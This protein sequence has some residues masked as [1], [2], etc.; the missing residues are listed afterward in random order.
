MPE[1]RES[2]RSA[3]LGELFATYP[4]RRAD[5]ASATGLSNATVSRSVEGLIAEGLA[6]EID[7]PVQGSRGRPATALEIVPDRAYVA[8]V[9][10]GAS[11]TRI[12]VADAVCTV[13]SARSVPTPTD[14]GADDLVSWLAGELASDAARLSVSLSRVSV[15]LPG[16]VHLQ[17]HSVTNAPNLAVVERPGFFDA[18][19]RIADTQLGIDNDANYALMG[20]QRYG[21]AREASTAVMLTIGAGLGAGISIEGKLLRGRYGLVGEFG[22]LPVGPLGTPLE[23][24]VTGPGIMRHAAELGIALPSPADLFLPSDD[25]AVRKLRQSFDQALLIVLAAA[26]V[27]CEPE[28]IVLGGG[29]SRS[30]APDLP[31]LEAALRDNLGSGPSLRLSELGEFSGAIGAV[32]A[33]LHRLYVQLGIDENDLARLPRHRE[34]AL[35]RLE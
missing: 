26:V 13:I 29:I 5:L 11:N 8:G 15:G 25:R 17:N 14:L 1:V 6:R 19:E 2:N 16:A 28:V 31:Q 10:L 18:L 9:D 32:I 27:S 3:V 23:N 12:V 21:A 33:S 30:L 35:S 4:T 20:E 22:Q 7:S 24:M 34:D